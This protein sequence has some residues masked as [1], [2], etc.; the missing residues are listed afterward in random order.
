[1]NMETIKDLNS[2]WWYRLL[3][4]IYFFSLSV[5][6]LLS[7]WYLNYNIPI[8]KPIPEALFIAI[9]T[10][11]FILTLYEGLRRSFYYVILGRIRPK[12]E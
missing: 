6:I 7:L 10:L 11:F 12:K 2:K 1:M 5:S 4:V 8:N 9:S 3:K